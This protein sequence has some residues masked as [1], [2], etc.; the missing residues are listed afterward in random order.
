MA[1]AG[2]RNGRLSVIAHLAGYGGRIVNANTIGVGKQYTEI[3]RSPCETA[4]PPSES[5][6]GF[7]HEATTNKGLIHVSIPRVGSLGNPHSRAFL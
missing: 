7:T 5:S 3:L 4:S 1:A 6:A 2:F